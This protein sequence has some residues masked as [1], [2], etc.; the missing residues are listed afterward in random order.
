M[1]YLLFK[2]LVLFRGTYKKYRYISNT[3]KRRKRFEKK[4]EHRFYGIMRKKVVHFLW[5]SIN[6]SFRIERFEFNPD[7]IREKTDLSA[8]LAA[9]GDVSR[10]Q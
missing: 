7:L 8:L 5:S 10:R 4:N 1:L 2:I 3:S 9:D 6:L